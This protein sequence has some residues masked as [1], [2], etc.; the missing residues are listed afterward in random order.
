RLGGFGPRYHHE[1]RAALPQQASAAPEL[2]IHAVRSV[3]YGVLFGG[4]AWFA[5]GGWW[6]AVLAAIVLAEV[7]LTLEDFLIE[8]HTRRLPASE[9]V[10]HTVLALNGGGVGRVFCLP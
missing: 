1:L 9:R 10:L 8:D 5:W 2:R 3:L 6:L 7:A 4:L